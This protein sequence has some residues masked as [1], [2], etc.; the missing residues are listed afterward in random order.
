MQTGEIQASDVSFNQSESTILLIINKY[1]Y[2]EINARVE[3]PDSCPDFKG[4]AKSEFR[5]K[6]N[7]RVESL[8]LESLVMSRAVGRES[9]EI[10]KIGRESLDMGRKSLDIPK[11]GRQSL[12]MSRESL[13]PD[14]CDP[15]LDFRDQF[16][17]H[18]IY[19]DREI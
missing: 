11:F 10:P 19:F 7:S 8:S 15:C 2:I 9:L 5:P 17:V 6:L 18:L 3:N 13:C 4:R 14:F 12:D 16:L 1:N